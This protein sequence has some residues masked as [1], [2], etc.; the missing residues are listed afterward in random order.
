MQDYLANLADRL[1]Q[2]ELAESQTRNMLLQEGLIDQSLDEQSA[3]VA[4]RQIALG[5][6]REAG[7]TGELYPCPVYVLNPD[8]PGRIRDRIE[9]STQ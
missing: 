5:L 8:F 2:T 4:S 7:L 6:P 3:I 9:C 1:R